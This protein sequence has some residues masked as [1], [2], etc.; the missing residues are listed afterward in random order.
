MST[1]QYNDGRKIKYSYNSS[2][3][4]SEVTDWNG[5]TIIDYDGN[6][7]IKKVKDHQGKVIGYQWGGVWRKKSNN[8][9]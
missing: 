9:S 1:I 4:I 8:L 7:R 6:G 2:G 3:K 5:K